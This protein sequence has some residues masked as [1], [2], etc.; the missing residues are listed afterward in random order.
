MSWRKNPVDWRSL[1]LP[2]HSVVFGSNGSEVL[3]AKAEGD[4]VLG[5]SGSDQLSSAFSRTALIGGGA[6]SGGV[7]AFDCLLGT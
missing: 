7:S 3:A 6:P 1:F 2:V 5:L 4:V